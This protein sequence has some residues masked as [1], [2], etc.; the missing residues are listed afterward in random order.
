MQLVEAEILGRGRIG[1]SA[2]KG[3]EV[4]DLADVVVP[5]LLHEIADRHVFDH[6]PPQRADGHL[7]H[8]GLLS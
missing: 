1:R 4:L 7:G 8:R 3:G 5:R 6:A 2:E